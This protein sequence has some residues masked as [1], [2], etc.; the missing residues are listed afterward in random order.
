M[1][2]N[3][4]LAKWVEGESIHNKERDECCPDFSCCQPGLLVPKRLRV[5]F[6][7]GDEEERMKMLGGFLGQ[8][9]SKATENKGKKVYI[10]GLNSEADRLAGS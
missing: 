2:P 10:G 3:E 9:M 4:Q 7:E 6:L 8:V 5:A 1:T